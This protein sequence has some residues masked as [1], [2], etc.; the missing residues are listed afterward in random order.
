MEQEKFNYEG[1]ID[2]AIKHLL[3]Q[4]EKKVGSKIFTVRL[5]E[6]LDKGG[7]AI[8]DILIVFEDKRVLRGQLIVL[9]QD[10][11]PGINI[12]ANFI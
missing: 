7:E 3:F 2:G 12:K 1:D 10:D 9:L 8:S 11:K 6:P 5:E 4:T